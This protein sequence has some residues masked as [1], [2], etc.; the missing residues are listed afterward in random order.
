MSDKKIYSQDNPHKDIG[1]QKFRVRKAYTAWVEY[2]VVADNKDE[3]ID[4][5]IDHGGIDRI[6]WSEGYYNDEPV[7]VV[8][9]DYNIDSTESLEAVKVAE[10]IPYEDTDSIDYEDPVWSTDEFEWNKEEETA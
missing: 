9:Q 4:A 5:V 3:A 6:E 1:K 8:G 2:D 7:E 10:C